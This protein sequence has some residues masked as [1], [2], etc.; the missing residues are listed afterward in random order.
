LGCGWEVTQAFIVWVVFG[1]GCM[2]LPYIQK[3]TYLA[4]ANLACSSKPGAGL[5]CD[6]CR[7]CSMMPFCDIQKWPQLAGTGNPDW[8][9]LYA[10]CAAMTIFR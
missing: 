7:G 5:G 1:S 2:T 6:L 4:C 10:I 8:Q 9:T 3:P